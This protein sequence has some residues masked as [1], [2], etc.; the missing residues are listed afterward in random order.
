MGQPMADSEVSTEDI[1]FLPD[2]VVNGWSVLSHRA[3]DA[4]G[5]EYGIV[6]LT[7]QFQAAPGHSAR[8]SFILGKDDAKALRAEL[9]SPTP[10]IPNQEN[11]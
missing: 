7:L 4:D 10:F 5:T 1:A 6:I 2:V 11:T 9:K 8:Q 3:H